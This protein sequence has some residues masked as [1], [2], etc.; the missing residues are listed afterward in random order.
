MTILPQLIKK[1]R[2]QRPGPGWFRTQQ[3]RKT[4][5][6]AVAA[7]GEGRD[8]G[9]PASRAARDRTED[10]NTQGMACTCAHV[11]VCVCALVVS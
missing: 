5:R 10:G 11:C 9:E 1:E 2:R 4:W 7:S 6:G 8:G 3:S